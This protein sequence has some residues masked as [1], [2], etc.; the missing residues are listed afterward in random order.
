MSRD[1]PIGDGGIEQAFG[2]HGPDPRRRAADGAVPY[3]HR[4]HGAGKFFPDPG[5]STRRAEIEAGV[6]R[7][8]RS[9]G[10][11]GLIPP[12][13]VSDMPNA[14]RKTSTTPPTQTG[15]PRRRPGKTPPPRPA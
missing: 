12:P 8:I 11:R 7:S 10:S 2:E 4:S 5:A 15:P 13:T 9:A 1:R 3:T 6:F 14:C